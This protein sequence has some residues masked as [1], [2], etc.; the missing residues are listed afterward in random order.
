M[1]KETDFFLE[2][3]SILM[4]S[5]LPVREA[6]GTL[7]EEVRSRRMLRAIGVIEKEIEAGSKVSTALQKSGLLSERYIALL[8]LGEETGELQKQMALIVE[9]QKKE[10]A[11]ISKVRG[12]LIYPG[13]VLTLTIFVGIFMMWYIFPKLTAIFMQGNGQLPVTTR[14]IIAT[15]DFLTHW[16]LIAVP[17]GTAAV[18]AFIYFVF[19]YKHTRWIGET[20]LMR[21]PVTRSIV[22]DIELARFGYVVGSLLHAGISLPQAL[23]SMQESTTFVLYKRF[24]ANLHRQVTEGSSFYKAIMSYPGHQRFIPSYLARLIS[25]GEMSGSLSE[26]LSDIGDM[27]ETKTQNLAQNLSVLLEPLI[28]TIV[29]IAVAFLAVAVISPI[30]GLT[31]QIN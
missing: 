11:L 21:V 9:T 22:E 28:I 15:G 29:G 5:A 14:M 17:L 2:N 7:K 25:A 26:T 20:V 8:R 3:L 13:V 1:A 10:R 19:L 4:R 23:V 12:A 30:Y 6:V 18:A 27:F 16:G 24:Y 31:T